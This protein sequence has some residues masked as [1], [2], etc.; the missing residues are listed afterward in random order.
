MQV[1]Y[2]TTRAIPPN[3]EL[4]VSYGASYEADLGIDPNTKLTVWQIYKYPGEYYVIYY[5]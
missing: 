5:V 4:M 1:Y 2:R 3:T